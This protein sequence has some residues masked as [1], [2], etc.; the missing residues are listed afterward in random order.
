[1]HCD[2]CEVS[3]QLGL[4]AVAM[5]ELNASGERVGRVRPNT[6]D[7]SPIGNTQKTCSVSARCHV[8][9]QH[10]QLAAHTYDFLQVELFSM[11]KSDAGA[12]KLQPAAAIDCSGVFD[13]KWRPSEGAIAQS[14]CAEAE[15][16]AQGGHAHIKDT[17]AFESSLMATALAD[18]SC[19]LM[20]AGCGGMHTVAVASDAAG[21]GMALSCD[22]DTAHEAVY[23]SSCLLYTSPSPR[24]R[25]KSRMPSSA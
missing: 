21:G 11:A 3:K 20:Q 18:G 23:C 14:A 16:T 7:G 25:Q 19:T 2:C 13:A 15:Q 22:W 12:Y 4:L 9:G 17:E 5:Y 1:M 6:L 24:D 10:A 8:A